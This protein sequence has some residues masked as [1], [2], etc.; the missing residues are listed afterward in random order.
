MFFPVFSV[1]MFTLML[2]ARY[3]T[4]EISLLRP[5]WFFCGLLPSELP[6][7]FGVIQ[8]IGTL[9]LLM[10]S[11]LF[12]ALTLVSLALS[13]LT[14][15]MWYRLHR[16]SF[17]A[18]EVFQKALAHGLKE[19]GLSE[20]ATK[21]N[22]ADLCISAPSVIA[23]RD[24]L[25]PFSF[26]RA[27]V[28]RIANIAYGS[29]P[30]QRLD[31]YRPAGFSEDR[32]I[33]WPVL[34]HVH[35]GGWISGSKR[36]QAQPLI[37]YLT[38]NGWLCVDINYRLAPKHRFPDC[39]VDVKAAIAWTKK[40]IHEY[41]GDPEF[42]ALTGGSAGAHLCTL[43]A[44]TPNLA[45]FQPGFESADTQVQA[46]VAMYGVFD[47]T[48][49]LGNWSGASLG[50]LLRWLV[51]PRTFQEDPGF[52][53]A[54]SPKHQIQ[55]DAPPMFVVHGTT[56]SLVFVEDARDFVNA[57]RAKTNAPVVYA[58]LDGAQHGFDLFHGVRTQFS[59]EAVG[60]FLYHCYSGRELNKKS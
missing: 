38:V 60:K 56:D 58:E 15:V 54:A 55:A 22:S 8:L 5:I 26:K 1:V 59:I 20:E 32:K 57:L 24:W 40:H 33:Q 51:M 23:Q 50:Q 47:C 7:L 9:A 45:Q 16:K 28:E 30:R 39:L 31:I 48:N 52:W 3:R 53:R 21:N 6:W 2:M 19:R 41:G 13:L 42:I 35:G 46:V 18:G 34:L 17:T 37:N 25:K 4:P 12:S 44:L 10:I 29:H 11:A 43:S 36:Q 14:L 27:G 49:S